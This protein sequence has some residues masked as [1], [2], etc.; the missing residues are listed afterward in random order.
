M[1]GDVA[2]EVLLKEQ[3]QFLDQAFSEYKD[4]VDKKTREVILKFEE[5]DRMNEKED[6]GNLE[7][8]LKSA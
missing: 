8:E 4:V 6:L 7:D 1:G 3:Q 2:N 5:I